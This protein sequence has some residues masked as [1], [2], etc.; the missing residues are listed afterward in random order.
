MN[1]L[2]PAAQPAEARGHGESAPSACC[3]AC[4]KVTAKTPLE[5]W[6]EASLYACEE[7]DLHF[8][9]PVAMP[10]ASWYE[11]AYQGRDQTA[12]P[13]EPGH[14]FFLSDPKAPKNGRL[15]DIG[16]G[17]GN[18]LAAAR[19]AGFDVTG[20][21][22][23]QNAVRFAREHYGLRNVSIERPEEFLAAHRGAKF[24][25]VTFFEVLEHQENPQGLLEVAKECLNDRGFVALSVPNRNRW[26]KA[27]DTLDFPPNHLTRW[28]PR[29]LRNFLTRNG[30]EILSMREEPLR[31][32]RAAQ[33]LST[34]LRTGL[35]SWVAGGS[36]PMLADMAELKP[37]EMKQA[38]ARMGESAGHRVASRLATWKIYL[39][40][41]IA[42]LL[43]PFL[44][45]R[46]YAGL[47]L[48]CLARMKHPAKNVGGVVRAGA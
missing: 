26:Q 4:E 43:L 46:G 44:R 28:S 25:V 35:V 45:R 29:A 24:D 15:L 27:P 47:Y 39:L 1:H 40:L 12:M 22:M 41:P 23:N 2:S 38:M 42:G 10:D 13:L 9:H 19:D 20:I 8:W 17:V 31:A 18:F 48:Y 14:R 16:C 34:G 37:E 5:A 7:C 33:V 6:H 11:T 21:E 30:F 32:I 36:P 3:P